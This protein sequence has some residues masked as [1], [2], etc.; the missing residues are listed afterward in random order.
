MRQMMEKHRANAVCSSCHR[1]DPIGFAFEATMRS[2]LKRD[3]D[4]VAVDA[5]RHA[6]QRPEFQ[7]S[8]ELKTILKEKKELFARCLAENCSPMPWGAVWSMYDKCAVD[9][10]M[11]AAGS[12]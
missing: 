10:I 5:S 2:A 3:K 11:A 4:G 9:T 12:R 8:G 6:S 7:R 1:M